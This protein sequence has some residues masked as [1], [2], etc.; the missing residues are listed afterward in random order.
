VIPRMATEGVRNFSWNFTEMAEEWSR[1]GHRRITIGVDATKL[2][3]KTLKQ[4][5]EGHD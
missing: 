5:E 3:L 4:P 2:P 1:G